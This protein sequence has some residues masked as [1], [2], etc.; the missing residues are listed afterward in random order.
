MT[1]MDTRPA[2]T[3]NEK[4]TEYWVSKK[5]CIQQGKSVISLGEWANEMEKIINKKPKNLIT[6]QRVDK[7]LLVIREVGF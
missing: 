1:N 5:L 7:K 6:W 2:M 4:K 3:K